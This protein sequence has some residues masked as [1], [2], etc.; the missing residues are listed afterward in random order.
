[1]SYRHSL[2]SL[3]LLWHFLLLENES[4]KNSQNVVGM[5]TLASFEIYVLDCR[6]ENPFRIP[7]NEEIF[8]VKED[9][10]REREATRK[11]QAQQSLHERGTNSSAVKGLACD[12]TR[13][14]DV[15]F[16]ST[17]Q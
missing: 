10:K 8:T 9:R 1:M 7:T 3:K 13:K 2:S 17:R 14:R 6:D 4:H 15:K 12:S 16:S 11:A 5:C